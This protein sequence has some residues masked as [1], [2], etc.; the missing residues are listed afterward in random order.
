MASWKACANWTLFRQLLWAN[1]D[2]N[3]TGVRNGVGHFE[4]KFQGKGPSTNDSW[5]QKTRVHGL[6]RGVVCV[7][8]R[9]AVLWVWPEHVRGAVCRSVAQALS[10]VSRCTLRPFFKGRSPLRSAPTNFLAAPLRE[11]TTFSVVTVYR[12]RAI[13]IRQ[14]AYGNNTT[15]LSIT[16]AVTITNPK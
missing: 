9:L 4:S 16:L 6:S 11:V 5:R 2:R 7:I 3:Y 1:I 10:I 14:T 13:G 12:Y 8:L 15:P